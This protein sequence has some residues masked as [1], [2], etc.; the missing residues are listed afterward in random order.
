M[1]AFRLRMRGYLL[2]TEINYRKIK[3]PQ[4]WGTGSS[5]AFNKAFSLV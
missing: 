4:G 3:K 1:E 5:T 2:H